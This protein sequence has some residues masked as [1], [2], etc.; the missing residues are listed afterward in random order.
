MTEAILEL[1][2]MASLIKKNNERKYLHICENFY[3][4]EDEEWQGK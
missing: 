4:Q 1:E 3:S 2:L